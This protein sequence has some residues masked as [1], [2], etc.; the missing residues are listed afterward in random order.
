MSPSTY[1]SS[2]SLTKL[3]QRHGEDTPLLHLSMRGESFQDEK[4][5]RW[6]LRRIVRAAAAPLMDDKGDPLE[7]V[8]GMITLAVAG[9][10]IGLLLPQN[11]ALPSPYRQISS[12]M[13]YSYV[14]AWSVSFYPQILQNARR[15]TTEG[16]SI[17]FALL[18][19]AGY[20]AYTVYNVAMY[21]S[22]TV[23]NEYHARYG[24]HASPQVQ[25]ND[26]LFTLHA[27]FI[28]TFMIGQIVYYDGLQTLR[29]SPSIAFCLWAMVVVS[30]GYPLAILLGYSTWLD[31]IYL[32]SAVKVVLSILMYAPQV[33][34][35]HKRRSTEGWSIWQVLLDITGGILS[36]FQL[37]WDCWAVNDWAGLQGNAAKFLLGFISIFFDVIFLSQ[38]YCWYREDDQDDVFLDKMSEPP[39]DSIHLP[40]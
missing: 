40:N 35:N 24:P 2:D 39:E 6:T 9:I 37:V 25:W 38:H 19:A 23:L 8:V 22:H 18:Y 12:V 30:L 21:W 1:A 26:V 33:I 14:L 15:Q 5:R 29:P 10:V 17:D 4:E 32:L 13:G 16:L 11:Q 36:A 28:T 27:I 3:V 31:Y 20:T 7:V 34:L